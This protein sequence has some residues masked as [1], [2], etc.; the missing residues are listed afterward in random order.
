MRTTT[1]LEF[2]F[3]EIVVQIE[4]SPFAV[5]I[6]LRAQKLNLVGV[7]TTADVAYADFPAKLHGLSSSATTTRSRT[8]ALDY[9]KA[10]VRLSSFH[11]GNDRMTSK[12]F[13]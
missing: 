11:P 13:S 1:H 4:W 5:E 10:N 6:V 12:G 7:E 8:V 2:T 3:E 9:A